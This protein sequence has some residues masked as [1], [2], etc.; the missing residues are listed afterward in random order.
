MQSSKFVDSEASSFN[1]ATLTHPSYD[2][3]R[4]VQSTKTIFFDELQIYQCEFSIPEVGW[5]SIP[6]ELKKSFCKAPDKSNIFR[7]DRKVAEISARSPAIIGEFLEEQESLLRILVGIYIDCQEYS[8]VHFPNKR[9]GKIMMNINKAKTECLTTFEN[10]RSQDSSTKFIRRMLLG[11]KGPEKLTRDQSQRQRNHK[12]IVSTVR[13]LK[14]NEKLTLPEKCRMAG[15]SQTQYYR[16]CKR[17][18]WEEKGR[19]SDEEQKDSSGMVR[20]EKIKLLKELADNPIKSYTQIEMCRQLNEKFKTHYSKEFVWYHLHKTLG[21]SRKRTHFR[22]AKAFGKGQDVIDYL[23]CAEVTREMHH[24]KLLLYLDES[25]FELERHAGFSY[26]KIGE[27]SIKAGAKSAEKLHLIMAVS[28]EQVFAY[29]IRKKG[30]NEFAFIAFLIDICLKYYSLGN[31][32]YKGIDLYFDNAAFH[33]SKLAMR[34]LSLIPIKVIFGSPSNCDLSM[35]ENIFGI[36]KS[37][38][39]SKSFNSLYF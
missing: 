8:A 1:S 15:I 6:A 7:I 32:S 12:E 21:Y 29:S 33:K 31:N 18:A 20:N 39:H 9:S 25:G 36:L 16:I 26:S 22:S 19:K 37:R 11:I 23:V 10:L 28:R 38:L 14:S 34:F 27:P 17:I 3:R 4:N 30:F 24:G 35:I 5:C 13:K 2:E